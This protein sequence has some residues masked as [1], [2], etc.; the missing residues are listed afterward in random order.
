MCC[1]W[2]GVR[3]VKI[4]RYNNKYGFSKT[5]Q[6][7]SLQE[8]VLYYSHKSLWRHNESAN[9]TLAYPYN[10][11]R[12]KRIMLGLRKLPS[13]SLVEIISCILVA[14]LCK[15]HPL[16]FLYHIIWLMWIVSSARLMLIETHMITHCTC[17]VC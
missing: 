14:I 7:N 8:L 11:W 6:H 13:Q 2:N 1:S 16:G 17:C 9:T 4:L 12:Q 10:S 15:S 3:H 5:F